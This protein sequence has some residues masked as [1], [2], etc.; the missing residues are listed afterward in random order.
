[1]DHTL[2]D[3]EI[4]REAKKNHLID[5]F[6]LKKLRGASYDLSVGSKAVIAKPD[7]LDW[8]SLDEQKV[9]QLPPS[10]TCVIYSLE[11]VNMHANMKGRLSLRSHY[12]MQRLEYNGGVVD[13]GYNGYLFFTLANLGDSEVELCFED[14]LITIEFILMKKSAKRLYN[15][16]W[17]ILRLEDRQQPPKLPPLPTEQYDPI[18]LSKRVQNLEKQ[19]RTLETDLDKFEPT[20]QVTEDIVQSLILASVAGVI[21]GLVLFVVPRINQY[22]VNFVFVGGAII[23]LGAVLAARFRRAKRKKK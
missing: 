20:L 11:K 23:F 8:I 13:P 15:D 17:E 10:R 19:F 18:E 2:V 12:A 4:E 3:V 9:L 7:G 14:P 1:M 6:D 22:P 21:A 16:G 5:P